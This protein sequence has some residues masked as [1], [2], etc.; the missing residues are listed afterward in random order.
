VPEAP[1]SAL[2][3]AE[4]VLINGS[5]ANSDVPLFAG[6]WTRLATF[7]S[8]LAR[9][10]LEVRMSGLTE[11][12]A[13]LVVV[14]QRE[15]ERFERAFF[16]PRAAGSSN[17]R[18]Y[19]FMRVLPE[20]VA[21]EPGRV[22]VRITPKEG[23]HAPVRLDG[24]VEWRRIRL[25]QKRQENLKVIN[26]S[27]L[28]QRLALLL[29]VRSIGAARTFWVWMEDELQMIFLLPADRDQ[30]LVLTGLEIPPGESFVRLY[31]P[32]PET[33]V[34]TDEFVS[35]EVAFPIHAGPVRRQRQFDL[36]RAGAY[37]LLVELPTDDSTGYLRETF[38]AIE[39]DGQDL[40]PR[41]TPDPERRVA[42]APVALDAGTHTLYIDQHNGDTVPVM[43]V[44]SPPVPVGSGGVHI[45]AQRVRSTR[46][47]VAVEG[48]GPY[49]L[50]LNQGYD[51]RWQASVDGRPVAE[52]FEVNGFANGWLVE[53]VG[54]HRV[55]IEFAPQRL[56]D[57][58]AVASATALGLL[59]ITL[60][61]YGVWA[62]RPWR[63][64]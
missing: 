52:H 35:F 40:L 37:E 9:V 18:W 51:P 49:V 63:L 64:A 6:P 32:D 31:S 22:A 46:Y 62:W 17:I 23:W 30:R 20:D 33:Q 54:D 7:G 12:D 1:P 29:S 11:D 21:V 34:T 43:L 48:Q 39:L 27:P 45:D 36:A 14:D 26:S 57:V 10:S 5:P 25:V 60:A 2:V 4:S 3:Q 24:E 42:R 55:D 59:A 28:P 47:R 15:R 8:Q 53:V 56:A 13:L 38:R 61:A 19:A 16:E 50:V 44:T 41:L 58:A